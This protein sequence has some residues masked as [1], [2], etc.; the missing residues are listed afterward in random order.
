MFSYTIIGTGAVGGYFGAKLARG[1]ATVRFLARSDY[2]IIMEKGL[3]VHSVAGDFTLPSVEVYDDTARIPES[4]V[5]AVSLKTTANESLPKLL[6]P[7]VKPGTIILMMQNGLGVET[8]IQEAFPQS[9]VAGGLCYICARKDGPGIIAH[10][11][12]GTIAIGALNGRL[13]D[14]SPS[15]RAIEGIARDFALAGVPAEVSDSLGTSRWNKLLW[16]VPFN[17][18][19]VA[20]GCDTREILANESSRSMAKRLMDEVVKGAA[21][22]GFRLEPGAA[23]KM[24]AFTEVMTPYEPSMKLDWDA[25]RPMEIETM[26]RAPVR[27]ARS[28]GVE[29]PA[30]AMLG[31]LLQFMETRRNAVG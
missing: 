7:L 16:N 9:V 23:D 17:G 26:Y 21:A 29:L 22:C 6:A 5:I 27:A 13:D 4:D 8:D 31:D 15:R 28:A 24:I 10:Q 25:G 19:S 1:G 18:L 12:K 14:D 30:I 11:D 2:G 20:L 3:T